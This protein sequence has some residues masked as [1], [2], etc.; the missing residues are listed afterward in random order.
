M[1]QKMITIEIDERGE[2]T[3][4]LEG[5]EGHGCGDVTDAFRGADRV[6][7]ARKKREFYVAQVGELKRQQKA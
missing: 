1:K 5:F 7:E 4:D 3:I 2:S 6:K